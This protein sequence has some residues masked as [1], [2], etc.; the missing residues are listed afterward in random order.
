MLLLFGDEASLHASRSGYSFARDS[1][2]RGLLEELELKGDPRRQIDLEA[3]GGVGG[4][5]AGAGA[6]GPTANGPVSAR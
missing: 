1:R 3:S 2:T 5:E 6:S 4:A